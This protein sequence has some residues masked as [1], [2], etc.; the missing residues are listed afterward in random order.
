MKKHAAT[1]N[2][3]L[4]F[5]DNALFSV[6]RRLHNGKIFINSYSSGGAAYVP[7]NKTIIKTAFKRKDYKNETKAAVEV[8]ENGRA[9]K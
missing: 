9:K 4:S 6:K 5:I 1:L 2:D 3:A 7:E 8:A